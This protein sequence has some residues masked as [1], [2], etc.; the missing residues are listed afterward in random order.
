[1]IATILSTTSIVSTLG[2]EVNG[3]ASSLTKVFSGIDQR[4]QKG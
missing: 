3:I 2:S 1:M 4:F